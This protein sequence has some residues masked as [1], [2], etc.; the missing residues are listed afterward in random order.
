VR[1]PLGTP[2]VATAYLVQSIN[3]A[4]APAVGRALPRRPGASNTSD[5]GSV[6][7]G[8]AFEEQEHG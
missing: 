6:E 5:L 7:V 8:F 3:V 2:D 1:D 4:H